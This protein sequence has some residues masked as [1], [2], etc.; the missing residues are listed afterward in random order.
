MIRSIALQYFSQKSGGQVGDGAI[1]TKLF[2]VGAG[3]FQTLPVGEVL[4]NSLDQM[5]IESA[6]L[7][8]RHGKREIGFPSTLESFEFGQAHCR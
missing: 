8:A 3:F 6:P 5:L 7:E 1:V 2:V 4:T